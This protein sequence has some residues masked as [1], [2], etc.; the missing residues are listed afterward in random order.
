MLD[1]VLRYL[2]ERAPGPEIASVSALPELLVALSKQ[3]LRAV[4]LSGSLT[5]ALASD[6]ISPPPIR[7]IVLGR[8]EHPDVLRAALEI[9]ARGFVRW[10][11]ERLELLALIERA[12]GSGAASSRGVLAAVWGPKGGSGASVLAAHLA[13]ALRSQAKSC[14]LVDLDLNHG[15]QAMILGAEPK[16]SILD[17]IPV[18]DEMTQAALE[19]VAWSH[20]S[21]FRA[22]LAPTPV[23]DTSDR[24][25]T[26]VGGLARAL[27]GMRELVDALVLDIHSGLGELPLLTAFEGSQVV[28][29]VTADLLALNRSRR[30]TQVLAAAGIERER[31]HPVLNRYGD[32][33]IRAKDVE[34]VLGC[35]LSAVV[36]LE[37]GMRRAPEIGCLSLSGRTL[38]DGLARRVMGSSSESPSKRRRFFGEKVGRGRGG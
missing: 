16:A 7:P 2:E 27:G 33:D 21:G 10:P 29:V 38:L 35:R 32:A 28:L 34:A 24:A 37:M 12:S 8:E 22:V 4:L 19:R 9:G 1:E 31:I 17:L 20:E 25:I 14:L 26:N 11:E 30:A 6:R 3:P 15:D 23:P 36:P 18:A 5:R 13:W